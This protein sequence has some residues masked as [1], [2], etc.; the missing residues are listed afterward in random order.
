MHWYVKMIATIISNKTW[1]LQ[2]PS[3]KQLVHFS[4]TGEEDKRITK[5]NIER[6][7]K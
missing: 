4:K 5:S 6:R 1:Y 3:C 7:E 2:Q